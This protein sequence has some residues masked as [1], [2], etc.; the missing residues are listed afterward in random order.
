MAQSMDQPM[1][2]PKVQ[3]TPFPVPIH[4]E[5]VPLVRPVAVGYRCSGCG[6]HVPH[7][8]W[9]RE[10]IADGMVVGLSATIGADGPVVHCCGKAGER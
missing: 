8:A 4:L 10:T 1:D 2:E 6:G 5:D 3:F 9:L 7:G